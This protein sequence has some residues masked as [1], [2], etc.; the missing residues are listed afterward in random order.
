MDIPSKC[1]DELPHIIITDL[2]LLLQQPFRTIRLLRRD[3]EWD[4]SQSWWNECLVPS[5]RSNLLAR[6]RR[7]DHCGQ[8]SHGVH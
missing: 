3:L 5:N 2:I 6:Q 1:L 7:F 4:S 8:T